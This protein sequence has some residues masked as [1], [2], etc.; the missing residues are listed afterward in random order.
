VSGIATLTTTTTTT[1]TTDDD[2]D[3]GNVENPAKQ[4]QAKPST[5]AHP[6]SPGDRTDLSR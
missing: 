5:N 6:P 3:G 1:T 4:L 2:D